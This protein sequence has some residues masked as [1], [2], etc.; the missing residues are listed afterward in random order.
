MAFLRWQGV[1][2][3]RWFLV[4]LWKSRHFTNCL[5]HYFPKKIEYIVPYL[6]SHLYLP[7]K[8]E[9][10]ETFH[11]NNYIPLACFFPFDRQWGIRLASPDGTH[12]IV[13]TGR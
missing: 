6:K 7:V 2:R 9:G 8:Y 11:F 1:D 10:Y 13:F 12:E 4:I 5:E 3:G